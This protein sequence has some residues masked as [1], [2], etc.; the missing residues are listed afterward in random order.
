MAPGALPRIER[1]DAWLYA[2]GVR[3]RRRAAWRRALLAPAAAV[4]VLLAAVVIG[5]G[6]SSWRDALSSHGAATEP[7]GEPVAVDASKLPG[8]RYLDVAGY[9]FTLSLAADPAFRSSG[10]DSAA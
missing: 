9:R 7:S 4:A 3:K 8:P 10:A 6:L 1:A 2:G 5:T